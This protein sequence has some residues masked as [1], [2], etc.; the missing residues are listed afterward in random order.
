MSDIKN[1]NKPSNKNFGI[2]FFIVF[3]LV[4]FY[5]L[6]FNGE[7]KIWSLLISLIFLLLGIMNSKILTP[8]NKTW[9]KFGIILGKI[10]SPIIMGIIFFLVVTPIGLIMRVF[11]KDILNL[12]YNNDKT[13]WVK[14]NGQ[15]SKMKNQF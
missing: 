10:V 7:I 1:N 15:K 9:H 2:V 4:A 11:K 5:P 6:T 14:K 8:L 3:L 12:E 13:Y